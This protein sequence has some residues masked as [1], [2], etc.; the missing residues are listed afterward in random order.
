VKAGSLILFLL[1]STVSWLH[2]DISFG[3]K[4]SGITVEA[5]CQLSVQSNLA[6]T[7]TIVNNSGT[8]VVAEGVNLDTTNGVYI[9]NGGRIFDYKTSITITADINLAA[10]DLL[11]ASVPGEG[12]SLTIAGQGQKIILT[13]G[14]SNQ[15]RI[16]EGVTLTLDGIEVANFSPEA[17]QFGAGSQLIIH[18]GTLSFTQDTAT[19]SSSIIFSGESFVKGSGGSLQFSESGQFVIGTG[20]TLTIQDV[21]FEA[22]A[23][24]PLSCADETTTVV[25]NDCTIRTAYDDGDDEAFYA[26]FTTGALTISGKCTIT[27]S[28]AFTFNSDATLEILA[29]SSLTIDGTTFACGLDGASLITVEGD[30][31]APL[32]SRFVL[33]NASLRAGANV[34]QFTG[35]NL[36]SQ[37]QSSLYGHSIEGGYS[38]IA[39]ADGVWPT[40]WGD[41]RVD[42]GKLGTYN[43][44]L[45]LSSYV[46]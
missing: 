2:A 24:R 25:L 17:I 4:D 19:V 44:D 34:T 12:S 26:R 9:E 35:I 8:V 16:A 6:L 18:D 32:T 31:T 13:P 20:N 28:G 23:R 27:G 3:D 42:S 29:S 10:K 7:G 11:L 30:A 15:L 40:N 33:N 22:F 43:I 1:C 21:V 46:P 38:R 14:V 45:Q 36:V 41:L 37:G 39:V 5:G